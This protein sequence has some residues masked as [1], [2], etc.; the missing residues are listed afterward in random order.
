MGTE[1]RV[2]VGVPCFNCAGRVEATV[3]QIL[4]N[5]FD[6]FELI[7]A[8]GGSRDTSADVVRG[9]A[10]GA[11]RVR[12]LTG[13]PASV[14]VKRNAILA[15]AKGRLLVFLDDDCTPT[16]GLI[17]AY[18]AIAESWPGLMTGPVLAPAG[19]DLN[20]CLAPRAE[21]AVWQPGFWS[22]A[23]PWRSGGG[24]NFAC[25]AELA[26]AAGGWDE[27][28][29][30]GAPAGINSADDT[31]FSL[32]VLR[33]GVGIRY[34]P[35]AVVYHP[36]APDW[37]AF[38]RRHR[39]YARTLILLMRL[40]YSRTAHGW[41]TVLIGLGYWTAMLGVDAL[42]LRR[43][44]LRVNWARLKGGLRG[45]FGRLPAAFRRSGARG[46]ESPANASPPV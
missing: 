6:D 25:P 13:L 7:L 21:P 36:P 8:E 18:A 35:E 9:L 15:E 45:L 12:A 44:G 16:K 28:L 34:V 10:D 20:L 24:G 5:D 43:D 23:L 1:P 26:R 27:R 37:A 4:A 29:G 30:P 40:K 17:G 42:R 22:K 3:Q 32:R 39:E 41:A 19:S 2:T 14:T 33:H 38:L 31:D 11:P 46:D